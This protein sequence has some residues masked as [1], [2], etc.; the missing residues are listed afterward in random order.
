MVASRDVKTSP[1]VGVGS[2]F[3]GF[4]PGSVDPQR[5]LVFAFAGGRAGVAADTTPVVDDK[6]EIHVVSHRWELC[7]PG[8][9]DR[10]LIVK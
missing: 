10:V 2:M 7:R 5:D 6:T 4:D 3:D 1:Q 8:P 9:I